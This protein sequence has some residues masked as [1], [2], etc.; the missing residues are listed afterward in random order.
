MI[1]NIIL[2]DYKTLWAMQTLIFNMC[3]RCTQIPAKAYLGIVSGTV[4]L[5][6]LSIN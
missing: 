6:L 1:E 4:I 2:T 5:Y 3:H